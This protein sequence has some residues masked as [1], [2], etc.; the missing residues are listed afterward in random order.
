MYPVIRV[1]TRYILVLCCSFVLLGMAA[2]GV[3]SQTNELPGDFLSDKAKAVPIIDSKREF[4]E[5]LRP[6]SHVSQA[7]LVLTVG[8]SHSMAM[9]WGEAV[10]VSAVLCDSKAMDALQKTS[11]ETLKAEQF[12]AVSPWNNRGFFG[13]QREAYGKIFSSPAEFELVKLIVKL[14]ERPQDAT[15]YIT[16][17]YEV[18]AGFHKS[19][20]SSWNDRT[21]DPA[22]QTYVGK[23][24]VQLHDKALEV[25][26]QHCSQVQSGA[27]KS[28]Q[29]ALQQLN[30]LSGEQISSIRATLE[31]RAQ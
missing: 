13:A 3:L 8:E 24:R 27:A 19:D 20:R 6:A 30:G 5:A 2:V 29:T 28:R 7:D 9:E 16:L 21:D 12:E 1:K 31:K 22:V 25:V 10:E 4:R 17:I 14:D 23:L 18:L 26:S 15:E 11:W